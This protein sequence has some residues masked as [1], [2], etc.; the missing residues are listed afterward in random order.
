[1]RMFRFIVSVL[2]LFV[3]EYFVISL[4]VIQTDLL[5]HDNVMSFYMI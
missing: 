1:M 4:Y 2:S 3:H 5:R